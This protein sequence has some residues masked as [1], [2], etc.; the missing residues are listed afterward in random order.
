MRPLHVVNDELHVSISQV[1]TWLRCPRQ[2]ELKYVRGAEPE[3]VPRALAF[4]SAFHAALALHYTAKKNALPASSNEELLAAFREVWTEQTTTGV[5][6][7]LVADEAPNPIDVAAKMLAVFHDHVENEDVE[8]LA[9]EEPFTA[10]VRNPETGEVLE[11]QLTG[12]IDLIVVEDGHP[13]VVEHKT[14]AKKYG[15]DQLRYDIQ[16]TAY[17]HAMRERGWEGIGLR[18]QVFTKTKAP[19]VQVEP[20]IRDGAD[21][22]DFLRVT[23]GVLRAIDAGVFFPLRGWQC[24]SCQFRR[25]CG[26]RP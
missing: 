16:P 4:G 9:V 21:E 14:S 17:Q 11:E 6:M 2:Y 23:V 13:V 3:M 15:N 25:R 18:F 22:N 19:Q 20:I 26:N 10:R 12:F 8:V 1:K 5:A 24:R 7:E